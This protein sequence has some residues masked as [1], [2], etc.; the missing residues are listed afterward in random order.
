MTLPLFSI[1]TP[2]YNQAAFLDL[3]MRSVLEQDYPA[4][5]Y[6]VADG[7]SNDGSVEII[8]RSADRLAWWISEK[9]NGQA[10]AINKGF[11]RITGEY[12][13]WLNSDD[14][15]LPGALRTVAQAFEEHPEVGLVF[16]DVVS[17]DGA[18]QP[19]N[20]MT[21]GP[22]ELDELM[23]FQII[24]QPGVFMRRSLLEQTG[25]LDPSYHFLLDH[26]LWLRAAM[27]APTLYLPQRLAAARFHAG[28]KNVAQAAAFGREAF[29]IIDWMQTQPALQEPYHRLKKRIRAGAERFDARYLQDG[30]RP[31][32]A[33]EAYLRSLAAHPPTALPEWRRML[34]ALASLV[35]D[36]ER[37]KQRY[38]ARRKN[39]LNLP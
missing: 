14:L 2:S 4:L 16:G 29:R 19:I 6:M 15:Y 10:E 20:V 23:C 27:R 17:I 24:S 30:G 39:R 35:V 3:T 34:Y 8:R 32:A 28:A 1:V 25:L 12:A 36:P 11:A 7:A 22:R 5:E 31:R 33:L 18:G 26:H 38:L 21:F 9:D 13:A 37:L